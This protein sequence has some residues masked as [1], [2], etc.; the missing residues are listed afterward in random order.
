MSE[1][2]STA[3]THKNLSD[4]AFYSVHHLY[5]I[6]TYIYIFLNQY[7]LVFLKRWREIEIDLAC[8]CGIECFYSIYE[9]IFLSVNPFS[10]MKV[11]SH[12][13]FM[14]SRRLT[15]SYICVHLIHFESHSRGKMLTMS[16]KFIWNF[17]SALFFW[18]MFSVNAW[19]GCPY[20][21]Q[22]IHFPKMIFH[23][24][25]KDLSLRHDIKSLSA[26]FS[27]TY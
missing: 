26:Y 22:M 14:C 16:K 27:G 9:H 17:S 3:L 1:K 23:F 8:V 12:T 25:F 11:E 21:V 15:C 10:H 4:F 5:A 7:R 13:F 2:D 20:F 6:H 24:G 19:W 18:W